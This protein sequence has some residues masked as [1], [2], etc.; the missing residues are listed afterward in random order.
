MNHLLRLCL[1]YVDYECEKRV[2]M[3]GIHG[4]MRLNV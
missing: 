3:I 2:E 4:L 1:N